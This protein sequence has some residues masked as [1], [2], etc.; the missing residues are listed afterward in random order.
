[1][2]DYIIKD[3]N[4]KEDLNVRI[5]TL[6]KNNYNDISL[7]IFRI[8][9]CATWYLYLI[10]N[11]KIWMF[12]EHIYILNFIKFFYKKYTTSR[13]KKKTVLGLKPFFYALKV[14]SGLFLEKIINFELYEYYGLLK[15]ITY[16][17]WNQNYGY[18]M[19]FSFNNINISEQIVNNNFVRI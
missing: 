8:I 7:K 5:N 6:L 16:I 2:L 17:Q 19:T 14:V 13:L 12:S 3:F 1:M 11:K 4:F 9:T 10:T 18:L 15:K